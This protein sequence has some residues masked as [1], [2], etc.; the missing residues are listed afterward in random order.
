AAATAAGMFAASRPESPAAG[1]AAGCLTTTA[2]FVPLAWA[3]L[4]APGSVSA[5][6]SVRT[7]TRRLTH[8]RSR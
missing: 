1:L 4:G 5:L 2:V 3:A 8:G 6:R 7:V